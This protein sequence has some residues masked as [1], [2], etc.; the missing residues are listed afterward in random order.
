MVIVSLFPLPLDKFKEWAWRKSQLEDERLN[1]L[2]CSNLRVTEVWSVNFTKLTSESS[3]RT[4]DINNDGIEDVLFGFGLGI[5]E[6]FIM[7]WVA[8]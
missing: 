1:L 3:V 8:F 7:T 5:Y 6:F 4:L 2:P